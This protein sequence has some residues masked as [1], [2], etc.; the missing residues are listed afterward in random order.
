[1]FHNLWNSKAMNIFGDVGYD[2]LIGV[3]NIG[4]SLVKEIGMTT[5]VVLENMSNNKICF[6]NSSNTSTYDYW[7]S[8]TYEE[9]KEYFERNEYLKIYTN[10]FYPN[11]RELTAKHMQYIADKLNKEFVNKYDRY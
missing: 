11:D 4:K 2:I 8:L 1:M 9:Q 7:M 3:L 5:E 6:Q 10:D